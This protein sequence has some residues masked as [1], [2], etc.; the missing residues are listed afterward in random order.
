METVRRDILTAL[1]KR[2]LARGLIAEP[3]YRAAQNAL[4]SSRDGPEAWRHL[5]CLAE[6]AATDGSSKN[7][8]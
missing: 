6:G 7:T 3:T 8:G 5:V 4:D 2:L 1:L